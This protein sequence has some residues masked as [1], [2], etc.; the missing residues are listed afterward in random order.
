[1]AISKEISILFSITFFAGPLVLGI[2]LDVYGFGYT[3]VTTLAFTLVST[4][5]VLYFVK[6]S[7]GKG[8]IAIED[9]AY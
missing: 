7:T 8:K 5:S 3:A 9:E 6:E 4:V 1:M 2:I